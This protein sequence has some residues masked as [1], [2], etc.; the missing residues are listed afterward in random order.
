MTPFKIS[1]SLILTYSFFFQVKSEG[2]RPNFLF[3]NVDFAHD[4]D[5]DD[6]DCEE[7]L[8]ESE[9]A[10]S[11][12]GESKTHAGMRNTVSGDS[13]FDIR[14]GV[15]ISDWCSQC[16]VLWILGIRA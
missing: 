2:K 12:G 8:V 13:N 4:D 3:G 9:K 16:R 14:E 10:G 1:I 15:R 6:S 7:Y 11:A 5:E